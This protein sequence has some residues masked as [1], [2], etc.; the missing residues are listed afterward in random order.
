M[1]RSAIVVVGAVALGL[2]TGGCGGS[3]GSSGAP[4]LDGQSLGD[5]LAVAEKRRIEEVGQFG[6][7]VGDQGGTCQGGGVRW[8]CRLVVV[9]HDAIRDART[10]DMRVDGKGCWVARQTGTDVG[11]RGRAVAPDHPETLKGCVS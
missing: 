9:L 3:D 4:V 2:A 1:R 7:E 8:T 11:V 10:Y 6:T 5:S